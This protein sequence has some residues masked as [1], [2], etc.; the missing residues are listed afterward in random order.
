MAENGVEIAIEE[1]ARKKSY[2][3]EAAWPMLAEGKKVYVAVGRNV[4]EFDPQAVDRE[5]LL[6]KVIG[7]SGTLR[8]PTL[9]VGRVWYVGF[10]P[11]MYA[12]LTRR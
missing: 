3:G 2:P 4:V 1:D 12:T 11:E 8:A 10:H 5:L 7:P 9:R 6:N